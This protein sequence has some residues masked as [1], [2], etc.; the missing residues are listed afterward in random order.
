MIALV[1]LVT[2]LD[3]TILS[4]QGLLPSLVFALVVGVGIWR[5]A[6]YKSWYKLSLV[7]I[8]M[9]VTLY[10]LRDTLIIDE[11]VVRKLSDW[12]FTFLVLGTLHLARFIRTNNESKV[13]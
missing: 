7:Y 5:K 12:A 3:V 8:T 2:L 10:L 4:T 13:N 6:N 11:T 1:F 9:A